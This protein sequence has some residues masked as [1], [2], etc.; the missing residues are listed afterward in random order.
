MG[1]SQA[2]EAAYWIEVARSA[3]SAGLRPRAEETLE[4]AE[5]LGLDHTLSHA[6]ALIRQELGQCQAAV[7][8]LTRLIDRNPHDASIYADR[9]L[10]QQILGRGESAIRDLRRALELDPA[11]LAAALTLGSILSSAGRLEEAR[12]V[13]VEAEE[14]SAGSSHPL[15]RELIRSRAAL[16]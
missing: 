8:I 16:R 10:C 7:D 14:A 6:A 12:R 2:G 11:C 4:R 15:R 3:L 13:Y 9:G 1:P 5:R